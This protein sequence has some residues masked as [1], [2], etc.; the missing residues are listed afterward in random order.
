[1]LIVKLNNYLKA[2]HNVIT[3]TLPNPNVVNRKVK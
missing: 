2:N 1:L 3:G